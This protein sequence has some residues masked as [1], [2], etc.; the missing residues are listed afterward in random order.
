M[1]SS[2]VCVYDT[3]G[4][5]LY[6]LGISV[7]NACGLQPPAFTITNVQRNNDTNFP[8]NGTSVWSGNQPL[9]PA[10]TNILTTTAGSGNQL[11]I[12]FTTDGV[13][14]SII[15]V[16]TNTTTC[17][18]TTTTT[19]TSTTT[20]TTTAAPLTLLTATNVNTTCP[21]GSGVDNERKIS[22]TWVGNASKLQYRL[23][24]QNGNFTTT[25]FTNGPNVAGS[26]SGTIS[27]GGRNRCRKVE[28]R[29]CT[30]GTMANCTGASN[31][32][33]VDAL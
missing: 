8:D 21:A 25:N 9:G 19:T 10:T 23:A 1:I 2:T 3:A 4:N 20:T 15:R 26:S 17:P 22:V 5:D 28:V 31:T 29:L 16:P 30:G 24:D 14:T 13:N 6:R 7:L 18:A 12:S 27:I 32:L 33:T 11:W